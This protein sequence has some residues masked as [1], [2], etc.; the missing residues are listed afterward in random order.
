LQLLVS[1]EFAG[2]LT[3]FQSANEIFNTRHCLDM[4]IMSYSKRVHILFY[5]NYNFANYTER[6]NALRRNYTD[7]P[8]CTE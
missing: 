8:K 7:M 4:L 3:P 2:K 6:K 1:L 5:N